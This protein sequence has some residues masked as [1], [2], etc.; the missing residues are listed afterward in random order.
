MSIQIKKY[1][2]KKTGKTVIKYYAVVF[3]PKTE[4][5]VW[6]TGFA[7]EKDAK[8]DEARLIEELDNGIKISKKNIL[9]FNEVAESWLE[10]TKKIYANS[11]YQ[12]YFWYYNKYIKDVFGDKKI[13]KISEIHIQ[14]FINIMNEQYSPATVNKMINIL[15]NIFK[16]AVKPLNQIPYNPCRDISRSRVPDPKHTTWTEK[17]I[18]YFL[19]LDAV[20]E[21]EYYDLF[22]LSF[23]TPI[24]PSEICGLAEN[25]LQKDGFLSLKRG[26]DRYGSLSD[27]KTQRRHRSMY[28]PKFIFQ[29]L[30]N[31][32]KL[33]KII[34]LRRTDENDFLF[35]RADG[36]PINPNYYSKAFNKI[37][38]AHNKKIAL[39]TKGKDSL[40]LPKIRLYDARHSFATNASLDGESI[41]VIADAMGNDPKTVLK[42]YAHVTKNI[43]ASA[44]ERYSN[45]IKSS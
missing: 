1:T 24:G 12:G 39:D 25:D 27:M 28:I 40:Y 43:H 21:H 30:K 8:K 7:R 31:R 19:N 22:L 37:L 42:N 14:K 17:Q 23:Y 38:E 4:K 34:R 45:R 16:F 36:T 2:S 15:S 3:D 44:L 9:Y 6:G 33:N 26:Y 20:K 13:D 35:I 11:T 41:K 32:I 29:R 5:R 10:A 18:N